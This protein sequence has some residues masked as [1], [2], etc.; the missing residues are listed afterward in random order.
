MNALILVDIQN[1]FLPGGSLYVPR[2]EEIIPLVNRLQ[3]EYPVVLATQDWHPAGH[4]S[5]A[6]SH[7]GAQIFDQI[8]LYGLQQT[9]WPDHCIQQTAGAAFSTALDTKNID[10]VFQKGT[11]P[12]VDS[13]SGFFDNG[14]REDTGLAAYLKAK[15]VTAIDVVGL[16]AD[17]CVYYTAMHGLELGFKTRIIEA[18]TRAIN[19]DDFAE[20]A[21]VFVK[22]GGQII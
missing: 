3:N 8:Q 21:Q 12:Q 14:K 13:Y 2:G 18:A 10:R 6:S 1:D 22:N 11:N 19:P 15:G 4:E 9:L 16:A 7:P 20:K 17:F 5:F